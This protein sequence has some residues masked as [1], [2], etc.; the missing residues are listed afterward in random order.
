MCLDT[1]NEF[2]ETF[3]YFSQM[4]RY[5]RLSKKSAVLLITLPYVYYLFKKRYK[6]CN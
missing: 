2:G 5:L 4:K 1:E 3:A 6:Y